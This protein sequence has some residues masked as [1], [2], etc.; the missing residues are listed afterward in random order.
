MEEEVS[1]TGVTSSF[2]LVCMALELEYLHSDLE[3][4]HRSRNAMREITGAPQ[5]TTKRLVMKIE[6]FICN[7]NLGAPPVR[8]V[9]EPYI[10]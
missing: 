3:N 10:C 7:M 4:S 5:R 2:G 1:F 6:E 8:I 9:G